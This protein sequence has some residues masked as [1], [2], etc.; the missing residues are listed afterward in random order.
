M[1][2]CAAGVFVLSCASTSAVRPDVARISDPAAWTVINGE[3]RTAVERNKHVV[4]LAPV[5]GNHKGSNTAVALV[6]GA[7][8]STG[9]ID[10]DLRGAG[11]GQASF[12]GIAFGFADPDR[13]EAIYFRPFRFR[14]T[15]PV[16]ASHAVQYVAWPEG[17]WEALRA[18][19]PGV[20]E[21]AIAPVPDP[22]SWFHARIEITA[23][24]VKVF[25]D[26]AAKPTLVVQRLRASS[27]P[28]GLWVDSQPGSF[29]NL[30]LHPAT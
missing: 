20:Y 1:L 15:D 16:E 5:G 12:I 17:T 18:R 23:T 7:T 29:A 6:A 26:G 8:F 24:T 3:T 28:I 22:A 25:V 4:E 13:Y 21:A 11:E 2:R 14:S 30:E 10:V 9:E 27:G 19:S